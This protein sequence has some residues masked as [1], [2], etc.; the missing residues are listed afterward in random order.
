MSNKKLMQE[1][2]IVLRLLAGN[3]KGLRFLVYLANTPAIS[4]DS[5][6][7]ENV[8]HLEA[9]AYAFPKELG[10]AH[11]FKGYGFELG[12]AQRE[13]EDAW[14]SVGFER[15][16]RLMTIQSYA[17]GNNEHTEWLF[18]ALAMTKLIEKRDRMRI[19]A[20]CKVFFVASSK[21]RQLC[22]NCARLRDQVSKQRWW[23]KHGKQWRAG[24][25]KSKAEEET[26]K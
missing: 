18:V 7:G 16:S 4:S 6:V 22:R 5:D 1:A 2:E 24:R 26:G 17:W 14:C 11:P 8:A 12:V 25:R 21:R 10:V 15:L 9:V 3:G 23:A 20:T 13:L 19:C